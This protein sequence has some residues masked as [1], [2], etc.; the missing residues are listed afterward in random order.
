MNMR[1]LLRGDN[2]GRAAFYK[3]M[4]EMGAY[5]PN[6]VLELEDENTLGADGDK[7]LVQLNLTTLE[8]AGEE[9]PA[10]KPSTPPADGPDEPD[11]DEET[12]AIRARVEAQLLEHAL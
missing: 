2:A 7:H 8:R 5:S 10:A 4:F 1:A 11:E 3:Q 9:P 12:Q 6:R